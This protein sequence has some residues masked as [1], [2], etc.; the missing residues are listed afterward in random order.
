MFYN[1]SLL[2]TRDHTLHEQSAPNLQGDNVAFTIVV[3]RQGEDDADDSEQPD[4]EDKDENPNR[5]EVDFVQEAVQ[6]AIT[7]AIQDAVQEVRY[8]PMSIE[9]RPA[10]PKQSTGFFASSYQLACRH[11]AVSLTAFFQHFLGLTCLYTTTQ[12][13]ATCWT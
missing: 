10:S 4:Q 11:L 5:V 6:E 13:S 9:L 8:E 7:E 1:K 12:P 3:N 2:T